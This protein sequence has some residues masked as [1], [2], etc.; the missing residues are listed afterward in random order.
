M[1]SNKAIIIGSGIAGIASAI[2]LRIKGYD[3]VIFEKNDFPGGKLT[4]LSI[5]AFRF[6]KGPSLF[7]MPEYVLELFELCGKKSTDYFDYFICDISCNYFFSDGTVIPFFTSK[8][9]T[10]DQVKQSLN[11]DIIPLKKH[12]EKSKYLYEQTYRAFIH[13]S[14][15]VFKNYFSKATFKALVSFPKLDIFTTMNRA[16]ERRLNH[17]KLIQ[18][19]NRFATYNGSDPYQAPGILNMIPHLEL[20]KGT[21][22]PKG[23]MKEITNSL[24][25]L[26]EDIGVSFHFNTAV[27]KII[28]KDNQVV[29]V[30]VADEI[31]KS[32]IIVCNADI[33]FTYQKLLKK[34]LINAQINNQEPSSSAV[35]F[36]L[37]INKQFDQLDLHNILFARDYKAEFEAIFKKREIYNDPTVYIHISSKY[38]PSDA[39]PGNENWFVMVNVPY[40]DGQDWLKLKDELR[41]YVIRKINDTLKE[42]IDK[43]IVAEDY[44]TP[45]MIEQNTS[46]YAGALYGS[47]SNKRSAAFFRHAN[48]SKIK[49][50]YHVGGSV[51]PGGGIP[52]CLMSAK[53]TTEL[54]NGSIVS[55]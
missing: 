32:S 26:A 2:R 45:K 37:G 49:G 6:D 41:A 38:C 35:I 14:L 33:K 31:I 5:G 13:Q 8:E 28:S 30:K 9:K 46:S 3:V 27:E 1:T 53:I 19:F 44:L 16:N 43:L 21:Y 54:I 52:L 50:L 25:K 20:E 42:D 51:H 48:F 23:G 4:S 22:F 17:P 36:Y 10:I 34:S 29:G 24:V 47:S 15:H 39:P 40:D 11:I 7:T 55:D 12:L 18:I